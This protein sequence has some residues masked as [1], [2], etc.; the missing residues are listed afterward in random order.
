MAGQDLTKPDLVELQG[1]CATHWE[2]QDNTTVET[3][4]NNGLYNTKTS[5]S[6]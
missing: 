1:I 6:R 5:Y 2:L 4:A 3:T